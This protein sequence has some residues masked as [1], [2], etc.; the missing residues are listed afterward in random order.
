MDIAAD[1][2]GG[3]RVLGLRREV[4]RE[5]LVAWGAQRAIILSILL[6][7]TLVLHTCAVAQGASCTFAPL[8]RFDAAEYAGIA[9]GGYSEVAQAAFA[10]VLPLLE[11]AV[12]AAT[13]G[14]PLPAGLAVAWAAELVGLALLRELAELDAGPD[15]ARRTLYALALFPTSVFLVMP[16]AESLFLALSVGTFLA[17][18]RRCWLLAGGL[19]ALASLTRQVGLLLLAP[20]ACGVIPVVAEHMR[21]RGTIGTRLRGLV[22][23]VAALALPLIAAGGW[24]WYLDRQLGVTGV[25]AKAVDSPGWQRYVSWPWDGLVRDVGALVRPEPVGATIGVARDLLFLALWV[26]LATALTV[27]WRRWPLDYVLYAWAS[28]AVV[29]VL[30]MHVDAVDALNSLPRYLIVVFP[31]VA[32]LGRWSGRS[33]LTTRIFL[34]VSLVLLT[35]VVGVLVAGGFIA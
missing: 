15:V 35:A 27:G 2:G 8:F 4:W 20:L 29:L 3:G 5:A 18:R 13:F 7:W 19:A 33:R 11:R 23:A 25:L 10:P 34:L 6:V 14:N 12:M 24:Q 32:V 26:A 22:P 16:Y 31:C 28:L 21:G 9:Q 30:P 17:V 1:A